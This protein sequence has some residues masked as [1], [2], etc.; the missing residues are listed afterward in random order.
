VESD[1]PGKDNICDQSEDLIK[2]YFT[3]NSWVDRIK[4]RHA[5]KCMKNARSELEQVE[6]DLISLYA[7][8]V[9]ETSGV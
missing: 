2:V 4:G 7:I 6:T 8:E 9:D 3:A 1:Q 5:A